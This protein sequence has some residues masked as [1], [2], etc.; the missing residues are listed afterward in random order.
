MSKPKLLSKNQLLLTPSYH[1]SS[2][3]SLEALNYLWFFSLFFTFNL[4]HFSLSSPSSNTSQTSLPLHSPQGRNDWMNKPLEKRKKPS[5]SSLTLLSFHLSGLNSKPHEA[6]FWSDY[7]SAQEHLRP[8]FPEA[9]PT[10]PNSQRYLVPITAV[11]YATPMLY[12]RNHRP[13]AY[14]NTSKF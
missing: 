11:Q 10:S 5:V 8:L 7:P 2:H 12:H 4:K 14:M 9:C 13:V 6:Q 1:S 3:L